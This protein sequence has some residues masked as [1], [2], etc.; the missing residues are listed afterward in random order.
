MNAYCPVRYLEW[1]QFA[2]HETPITYSAPI[3]RM[4]SLA[5][6]LNFWKGR[7]CLEIAFE[8]CWRILTMEP[9]WLFMHTY[10]HRKRR[11]VAEGSL[12]PPPLQRHRKKWCFLGDGSV[13]QKLI[14]ICIGQTSGEQNDEEVHIKFLE[15]ATLF[16]WLNPS[17]FGPTPLPLDEWRTFFVSL[18]LLCYQKEWGQA[19]PHRDQNGDVTR[20]VGKAWQSKE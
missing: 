16:F 3:L 9:S 14:E 20:L 17:P 7:G 8:I 11:P 4:I 18:R 6:F 19:G 1:A 13:K 2:S 5:L 12:D 10:I 15:W